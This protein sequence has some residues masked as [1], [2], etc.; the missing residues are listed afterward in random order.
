[1]SN[2]INKEL[3]YLKKEI[4]NFLNC[5]DELL[6]VL[7]RP[8]DSNEIF[9]DIIKEVVV[10]K[11]GRSLYIWENEGVDKGLI[12]YINREDYYGYTRE[13]NLDKPLIFM[14]CKYIYNVNKKYDLI[15]V[16]D[17]SFY[18]TLSKEDF[19]TLF[20]KLRN[21]SK[22][23]I[24]YSSIKIEQC[25]NVIN[26]LNTG[27]RGILVEPRVITTRINLNSDIPY[28]LYEYI[29]WFKNNKKNVITYVPN[30]EDVYNV[31]DYYDKKINLKEVRL[32]KGIDKKINKNVFKFKD[33]SIFLITNDIEEVLKT[34]NVHGIIVL[35]ADD[36]KIDYK[37][38]IFM[39]SK[40]C[41]NIDEFSEVILV[42]HEETENIEMARSITRSFNKR[43]W[44]E[45]Y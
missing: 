26:T 6:T 9:Y 23:I 17:I 33:K 12:S 15:I 44:E 20:D 43:L 39:C 11:G 4:N 2:S 16:D 24:F 30:K 7:G 10:N 27:S 40:V 14:N 32:I 22:K 38:I 41:K 36:K 13:D 37:K 29:K 5:E 34:P 19:K 1:M 31:Y 42:C 25:N 35:S 3:I 28:V 8:L 21:F 18:S 45:N